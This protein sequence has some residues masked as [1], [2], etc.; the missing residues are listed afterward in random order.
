MRLSTLILFALMTPCLVGEDEPKAK[1]PDSERNKLAESLKKRLDAGDPGLKGEFTKEQIDRLI[2]ILR[3]GALPPPVINSV[4][5]GKPLSVTDLRNLLT[6]SKDGDLGL[7]IL[8]ADSEPRKMLYKYHLAQAQKYFDARRET[9]AKLSTPEEIAKRQQYLKAKFIEALGGFP[10]KKS[11]LNARK[12][13]DIKGDGFRVEK[14]IFESRPNHHV[15]GNLYVPAGL[16]KGDKVPGVLVPC[17]HSANG[18]AAEPYQKACM[19]L[20]QNG[21]VVFCYDPIGQGERNQILS[22]LGRPEMKSSTVEHS[23]VG[24]GALLV[25]KSTATYRIWDGLRA[26]DYLAERPEVDP[27][28]LGCTGNSGGGTLTAYLMALDDRIAC[29]APSCYITTLEKLF[30]TLGPQDAEQNI[31]G[32]VAFGMDHADYV[33]M[34][35]P[36]PTLICTGTYDYFDIT[37]A[38]TTYREAQ[39]TYAKLG[40]GER[41]SLFEYPDKHGFSQPRRE[42]AARWMSRWLRGKDVPIKEG[43]L[44]AFKDAELQCTRS[45]QV[46][47]DFK[48]KSVFHFNIEDAAA[49]APQRAKFPSLPAEQRTAHMRRLLGLPERIPIAKIVYKGSNGTHKDLNAYQVTFLTEPGIKVPGIWL[50]GA[51]DFR[52]SDPPTIFLHEEGLAEALKLVGKCRNAVLV[53]LRGL[54]ETAPAAFKADKPGFFGVDSKD[55]FMGLHLNRPLLGQR[56]FDL[57]SVLAKVAENTDNVHIVSAGAMVG[58]VVLHAAALDPRIRSVQAYRTLLSW[59]DVV[60]TPASMNQLTNAVPGVLKVYDLPELAATLAPRPLMLNALDARCKVASPKEV[61]QT[62]AP[63]REAYRRHKAEKSLNLNPLGP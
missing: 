15:T 55:A 32:Q 16:K 25:G 17:G 45:G 9:V 29:A 8:S 11:P 56:V 40:F 19:I 35:A 5:T 2:K 6:Q 44:T 54:G 47:E 10:E 51:G 14:I 3:E 23:L 12:V 28:K 41:V 38:W 7:P 18:K 50:R 46:L 39:L 59:N 37:G 43:A 53:D 1:A 48:G 27:A 63:C 42:A 52:K 21:M 62:Y 24:V 20:A 33:T 22:P 60:H 61:E 26:M 34:R 13:G 49:F 58:P 36:R 31:T 30:N 57:L 4:K